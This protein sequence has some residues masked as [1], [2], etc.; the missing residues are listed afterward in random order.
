MEKK[1]AVLILLGC[2]F[3][4]KAMATGT[5]NCDLFI[6]GQLVAPLKLDHSR[7]TATFSDI[8]AEVSDIREVGDE[9]APL[10]NHFEADLTLPGL[11]GMASR[12]KLDGLTERESFVISYGNRLNSNVRISCSV[13]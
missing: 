6:K 4:Q 13:R 8:T 5:L 1:L 3:G 2:L 10:F 11:E 9:A 12:G 7:M